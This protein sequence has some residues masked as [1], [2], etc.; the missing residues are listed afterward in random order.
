MLEPQKGRRIAIDDVVS[1][2]A[3]IFNMEASEATEGCA[4]SLKLPEEVILVDLTY[5]LFENRIG[6]QAHLPVQRCPILPARH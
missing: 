2:M 1:E 3:D 4:E 6:L 5:V